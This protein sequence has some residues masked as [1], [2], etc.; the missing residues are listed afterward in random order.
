MRVASPQTALNRVSRTV[1]ADRAPRL[2]EREVHIFFGVVRVDGADR[3]VLFDQ[4][5]EKFFQQ[6]GIL[7]ALGTL[8]I[9]RELGFRLPKALDPEYRHREVVS[10]GLMMEIGMKAG[11]V[12][13]AIGAIVGLLLYQFV[14]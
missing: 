13:A 11:S 3:A 12:G 6:V 7:A 5:I 9:R 4:E 2:A 8:L 1:R 14:F 10:C